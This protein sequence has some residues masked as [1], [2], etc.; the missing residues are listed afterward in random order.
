METCLSCHYLSIDSGPRGGRMA[1][2][3]LCDLAMGKVNLYMTACALYKPRYTTDQE[4]EDATHTE[5]NDH[6][7]G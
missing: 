3:G 2:T 1:K 6:Q 4:V 5:R 7:A